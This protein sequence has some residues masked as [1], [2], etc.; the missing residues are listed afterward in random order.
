VWLR[1]GQ[2]HL[3]FSRPLIGGGRAWYQLVDNIAASGY[4]EQVS[5]YPFWCSEVTMKIIERQEEVL[6]CLEFWHCD[7][8][9]GHP[10]G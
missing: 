7:L 6:D 3:Q 9:D 10:I 1:D 5:G 2:V 4:Y 8:A